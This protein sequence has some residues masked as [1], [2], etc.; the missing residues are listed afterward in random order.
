M[1]R[2]STLAQCAKTIENTCQLRRTLLIEGNLETEVGIGQVLP[3]SETAPKPFSSGNFSKCCI[4]KDINSDG[5]LNQA[6]NYQQPPTI[7]NLL[8]HL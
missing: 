2:F 8:Q 7:L 3:S 5:S 4:D 6:N 1:R